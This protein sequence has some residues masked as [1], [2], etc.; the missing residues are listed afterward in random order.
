MIKE[1]IKQI[2]VRSKL[3]ESLIANEHVGIRHG[4]M[5]LVEPDLITKEIARRQINSTSSGYYLRSL[6]FY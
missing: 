5:M 4:K 6:Y 2:I 1:S 3:V